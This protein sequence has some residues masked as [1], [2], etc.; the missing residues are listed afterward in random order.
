M[1]NLNGFLLSWEIVGSGSR[2][3]NEY[4]LHVPHADDLDPVIYW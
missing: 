3:V 1:F 4:T 2:D